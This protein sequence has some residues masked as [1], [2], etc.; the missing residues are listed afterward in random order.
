MCRPYVISLRISL[1]KFILNTIIIYKVNR[2]IFIILY[3]V[4]ENLKGKL[5]FLLHDFFVFFQT[6]SSIKIRQSGSVSRE[7]KKSARTWQ[8]VNKL[9][10]INQIDYRFVFIENLLEVTLTTPSRQQFTF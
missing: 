1:T 9:P 8:D 5:D 7:R 6:S 10:S 4:K 2:F 3:Y